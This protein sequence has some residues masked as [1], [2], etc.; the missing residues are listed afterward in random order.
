MYRMHA[1][2]SGSAGA[3][4][5]E[6]CS[7]CECPLRWYRNRSPAGLWL[8]C[9]LSPTHRQ[10]IVGTNPSTQGSPGPARPGQASGPL[11]CR[12]QR[13]LLP[14]LLHLDASQ[15]RRAKQHSTT[16]WSGRSFS[17]SPVPPCPQGISSGATTGQVHPRRTARIRLCCD[18]SCPCWLALAELRLPLTPP[19]CR[20]GT[21][22]GCPPAGPRGSPRAP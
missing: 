20:A 7:L 1:L 2:S 9:G 21:S 11:A 3:Q 5:A 8:H 19:R 22:S 15:L 16:R 17:P 12:N 10:A 13:P 14:A 18:A 6:G 4:N